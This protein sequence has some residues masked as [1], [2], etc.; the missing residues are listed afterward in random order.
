MKQ[1]NEISRKI[2]LTSKITRGHLE[3]F[4]KKHQNNGLTLDIGCGKSP[5]AKFFPNRIGVDI[6]KKKNADVVASIYQLP[7]KEEKFDNILCIEVLEHLYFPEKAIKQMQRVLKRKGILILTTRFLFP[8][9]DVPNDYYR[10]TKYGLKYLF[11]DWQIIKLEEET[12]TLETFS[13]LLQ[14]IAYQCK[15][16]L[17]EPL[18]LFIFLIAKIIPLF[19]FLIKKEYGDISKTKLETNIMTSGYYLIV[20]KK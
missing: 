7:F 3:K 8:L 20:R 13:V 1:L 6:D 11:K 2:G 10:F 19:S 14:R 12:N 16:W 9:H 5:Y 17:L 18:K 4:I 15:G